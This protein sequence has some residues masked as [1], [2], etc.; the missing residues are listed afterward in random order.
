[1]VT[2][3]SL[4][5]CLMSEVTL[6]SQGSPTPVSIRHCHNSGK[7]LKG[8]FSWVQE[9]FCA[10]HP[11][12]QVMAQAELLHIPDRIM[13]VVCGTNQSE[14]RGEKQRLLG[15]EI[16]QVLPVTGR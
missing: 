6:M 13:R 14:S 10:Q 4:F 12:D 7:T 2:S 16:V 9:A 11:R 8:S 3:P 1:M 15:F 5:P